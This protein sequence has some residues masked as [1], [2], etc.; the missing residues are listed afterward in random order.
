M[1]LT[2]LEIQYAFLGALW[3]LVAILAMAFVAPRCIALAAPPSTIRAEEVGAKA[4][5]EILVSSPIAGES[6]ART[7]RIRISSSQITFG[8]SDQCDIS[9]DDQFLSSRHA[10]IHNKGGSL[11]IEDLDSTNGTFLNDQPLT[12]TAPLK[13]GDVVRIG[14]TTLTVE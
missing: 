10:I 13:S 1:L 4:S 6:A 5:P 14:Q 9:V 12:G 3:L 7:E 2:P 8:R 11:S